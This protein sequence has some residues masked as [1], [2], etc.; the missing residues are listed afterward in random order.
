MSYTWLFTYLPSPHSPM[1]TTLLLDWASLSRSDRCS[2][3]LDADSNSQQ[4]VGW[5]PT[6]Q[7]SL[8][9]Y[10]AQSLDSFFC[11]NERK[12]FQMYRTWC[13]SYLSFRL[14][15]SLILN[16][17]F[18]ESA[19]WASTRM[20]KWSRILL[21]RKTTEVAVATTETLWDVQCSKS[22]HHHQHTNTRFFMRLLLIGSKAHTVT[23]YNRAFWHYYYYYYYNVLI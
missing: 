5:H 2:S 19:G 22:D 13:R 3:G 4:R 1:A 23:G 9:A 21:Q 20:P 18:P 7:Y 14:R 8:S 15:S 16:G 10:T 12:F 11:A 17:Q 6:V